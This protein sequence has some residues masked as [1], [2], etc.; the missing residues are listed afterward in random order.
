MHIYMQLIIKDAMNLT[1]TVV[2]YDVHIHTRRREIKFKLT[3]D[4]YINFFIREL[5]S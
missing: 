1:Q 2:Y 5:Y 4:L 3:M